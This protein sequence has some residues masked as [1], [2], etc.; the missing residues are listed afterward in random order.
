[1]L[2]FGLLL[3]AGCGPSGPKSSVNKVSGKVTLNG[4][5]VAGAVEFVGAD[6]KKAECPITPGTGEY[7]LNDPPMGDVTILVKGMAM[8]TLAGSPDAAK[9]IDKSVPE[10][11]AAGVA[12][13]AKYGVPNNDLKFK[14]TGGD[15]KYDITLS[16]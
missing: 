3:V 4:Q 9:G 1:M 16:P 7:L 8:P 14:V 5:P 13:P 11:K 12:P 6:G 10:A 2:V 15:Q